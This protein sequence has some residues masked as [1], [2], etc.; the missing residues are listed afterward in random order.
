[1]QLSDKQVETAA[2]A[3][4]LNAITAEE[5]TELVSEAISK[6]FK[7]E[8]ATRYPHTESSKMMEVFE[9]AVWDVA[10][11]AVKTE[12]EKPELREKVSEV[13]S[14]ALVKAFEDQD[15]LVNSIA[16]LISSSFAK[17]AEERYR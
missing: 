3:A 1:M 6:L 7:R 17:A 14:V 12:F 4:I 11:E 8:K 10:R 15:D 16:S 5:R 13:V 2:Q 9:R